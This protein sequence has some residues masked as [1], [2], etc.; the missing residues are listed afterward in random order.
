MDIIPVSDNKLFVLVRADS[1]VNS[2]IAKYNVNGEI[3]STSSCS[4][5][6]P[7]LH[8]LF[9]LNESAYFALGYLI[10]LLGRRQI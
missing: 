7:Y 4:T 9:E 5:L 1:S 2:Y 10:N 8:R 3:L 6:N